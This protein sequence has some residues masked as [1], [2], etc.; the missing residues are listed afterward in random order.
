MPHITFD[1]RVAIVTGAASG[2]GAALARALAGRGC[3]LALADLNKAGLK[4][5]AASCARSER[6]VTTSRVDVG[7]P[8]DITRFRD[9]VEAAHGQAN[10]LFNNAGVAVGGQFEDIPP[11]DFDWLFAINFWGVVRMTRAFLPLLRQADEAHI[12]NISSLFGIIAPVGQTAYSASKFAVRGFSDAL[13]HELAETSVGVTTV[14]PGG[15][16]TQIARNA[17]LPATL[18]NSERAAVL[19]RSDRLL[20]L[21]PDRAA[22]II[23]KGVE[24]KTPRILVG[25]DAHMVSV[26]PE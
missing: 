20:T 5:V 13:R 17:R 11:D 25:R 3:H 23:L 9:Q 22:A 24:R 26:R 15:V 7:N 8:D 10:F 6:T 21:P 2:I 18:S 19:E 16:A 4:E 14:H 12:T 1:G